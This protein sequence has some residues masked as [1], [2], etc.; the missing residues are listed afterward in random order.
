MITIYRS[1]PSISLSRNPM[2]LQLRVTDSGGDLYRAVGVQSIIE[3]PGDWGIVDGER[4][5]VR[6][7]D[8][9]GASNAT[10]FIA[11]DTPDD[12]P[13]AQQIPALSAGFG[14]LLEYYQDIAARLQ[15]SYYCGP[16]IT[17]SATFDGSTYYLIAEHK[18][19]SD[20]V[21]LDLD[22]TNVTTSPNFTKTNNTTSS[23]YNL[24]DNH[25]VICEVFFESSYM[26]SVYN[27]VARLDTLIDEDGIASFDVHE[28]LNT[29]GI[30]S[31]ADPAIPEFNSA[32]PQ[33]ADNTRRYFVRFREDY[34]GIP[35]TSWSIQGIFY[36]LLGGIDLV[37][38]AQYDFFGSLGQANSLL[39]WYPSGKTVDTEQ[40]EYLAWY[41]Y[42]GST[43]EV[44]LHVYFYD[45]DDVL[46]DSIHYNDPAEL[47]TVEPMETALIPAG[48][49]QIDITSIA[50][51]IK[52]YIVKVVDS[53]D[54]NTVFSQSRI[55]YVDHLHYR[56]K[57]YIQYL[58]G[59]GVPETLRCVGDLSIDLEVDREN[60]K[61]ILSPDYQQSFGQN[62][63]YRQ[64]F[65][66]VR[67]Y[68]SGYLSRE[69]V[70][71]L[72]EILIYNHLYQVNSQEQV[73]LL[74]IDNRY[75][76]TSTR[77]FLHSIEFQARRATDPV[78]FSTELIDLVE[79][80]PGLLLDDEGRPLA[81][82][83]ISNILA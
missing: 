37:L 80:M 23:P 1:L 41:N 13:L 75:R 4:L 33:I 70:E 81:D 68:R 59:F 30:E 73:R 78:N 83:D 19:I 55:Y 6:W 77:Q 36:F 54:P 16:H 60:S 14:S 24:P 63:Q 15:S 22:A 52:K 39:T 46:Q 53:V 49:S 38:D 66:N 31:L 17:F 61:R 35:S 79:A 29:E 18:T 34:D 51:D 48:L 64:E 45:E 44:C 50:Y 57:K 42:S 58:N 72:Q 47:I 71:A 21:T 5:W 2:V 32:S 28:I 69:E 26:S 3:S 56:E 65:I 82:D 76:I 62:F 27:K 40:P 67:T 43:V 10:S 9:D 8:E 7:T 25:K 12:N 74:I 20:D 11:R